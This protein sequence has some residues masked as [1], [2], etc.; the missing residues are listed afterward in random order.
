M[1]ENKKVIIFDLDGTLIDSIGIWSEIDKKLIEII[2]GKENDIMKIAEERDI[3]LKKF[4]KSEDAYLEYCG[5]LK[6]K[7][8][9]DMSKEEIK[10]KRYEIAQDYLKN[11]IKYKEDAGELL[12]FLK[13]KGYILA[14]ATTTNDHTIEIY[15]HENKN[16]ME[17][18]N[19]EDIF[20]I[21]LSKGSVKELKP[22]PEVHYKIMEV[23]KVKPEEC[24]IF[25]DTI[26]GVEAANAA[27]I[28]VAVIYDKYSDGNRE[29]INKLS[30]YQ[31]KNFA[32]VLEKIK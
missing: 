29:K 8:N 11:V 32:E 20:S 31:F 15:K 9:S 21:I 28:E 12:K 16:I 30:Q 5:V 10:K 26:V 14:L 19:F 27:G 13:S 22:N 2:G 3:A 7:Y 25:E 4:N 24:L 17:Q 6:E 1:L 23:L 18:A